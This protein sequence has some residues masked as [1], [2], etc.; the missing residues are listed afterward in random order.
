MRSVRTASELA[1]STEIIWM[2]TTPNMN[3]IK[4]LPFDVN[5]VEGGMRQ[6]SVWPAALALVFFL[7]SLITLWVAITPSV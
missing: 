2:S 7:G 5:E 3:R 4:Q 1:M 6:E